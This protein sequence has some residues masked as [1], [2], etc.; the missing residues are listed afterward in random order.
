MAKEASYVTLACFRFHW[1]NKKLGFLGK[2]HFSV[3]CLNGNEN[4]STV[5]M[6]EEY[7]NHPLLYI[8]IPDSADNP[9]PWC[10]HSLIW[11]LLS[12][13]KYHI[14]L[15]NRENDERLVSAPGSL[16]EEC[17][18]NILSVLQAKVAME[19]VVYLLAVQIV[20]ATLCHI[21]RRCVFR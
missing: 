11:P 15:H 16:G 13:K 17:P 6:V 8:R 3:Y 18:R 20:A 21:L 1:G 5:R 19:E 4:T 2:S 12:S 14:L 7:F 9:I 10:H